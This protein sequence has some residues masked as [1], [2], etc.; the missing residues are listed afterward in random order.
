[1][2]PEQEVGGVVDA[3]SDL[4]C[5]GAVLFE[6]LVG[7]PPPPT[8][9][10]LWLSRPQT[11]AEGLNIGVW[12]KASKFVPPRWQ[13]VL[14]SAMATAPGDRYQDARQFGQALRELGPSAAP[15]V[16]GQK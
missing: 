1:M 4:Y 10:G 6:C 13:E 14:D 7:E 3:R 2:S 16:A 12:I 11:P 8:P 5:L 9:S 15:N